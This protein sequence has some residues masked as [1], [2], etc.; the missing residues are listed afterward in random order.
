MHTRPR[1]EKPVPGVDNWP[2]TRVVADPPGAEVRVDGKLVGT[3]PVTTGMLDPDSYH[4]VIATLG[5]YAPAR[6]AAKLEPRGVT[7]V[8]LSFEIDGPAV[9]E[10]TPVRSAGVGYLTAATKP[11]ARLT[12]DG[13]DTGRWTP[14]AP[15]NPIALP[16]GAHTIVFET[17]DGRRLEEQLQIEPGKTARLIRSLP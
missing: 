10:A 9:A 13:R 17:A 3:S 5:G 15:A 16:A 4:R 12:I 8:K 2:R 6:R 14:V 11:A 7:E 1:A